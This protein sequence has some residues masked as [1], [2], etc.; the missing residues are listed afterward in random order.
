[1]SNL[2]LGCEWPPIVDTRNIK[3][4]AVLNMKQLFI[5]VEFDAEVDLMGSPFP[6]RMFYNNN[7][8]CCVISMQAN[9]SRKLEYIEQGHIINITDADVKAEWKRQSGGSGGLYML[10][11]Y[12][13]WR[14]TGWD[15]TNGKLNAAKT[16]GC[17]HKFFPKPV[18]VSTVQ[19]LDIHAFAALDDPDELRASIYYLHNGECAVML[20]QK[21]IDQF[22]AGEPWHLTGDDG[23]KVGGHALDVPSFHA[24]GS[25]D[26]W[27]WGKRQPMDEAWFMARKYDIFAAVDNRD[28][29]K[30]NNPTD[31]EKFEALLNEI[32][33]S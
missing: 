26:D 30:V 32:V 31:Y 6:G 13:E 9:V 25:F 2:M 23:E 29:F 10:N 11:A 7:A 20:Y 8:P 14:Q 3:L 24:D 5:P 21:D 15:I 22:N 28:N 17:W 1:M 33:S 18:P 4:S 27:S 16:K 12:N 19:H